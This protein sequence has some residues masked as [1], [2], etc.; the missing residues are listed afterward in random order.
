[1]IYDCFTFFN[2]LDLLEIRL[3]I[4]NDTVDKFVLVEAT[5]T[6]Q[7]KTKPL[8][9]SE[10]RDRFR[11]FQHKII[12]IVV[13]DYPTFFSKW[14]MPSAWDIE[15]HQRNAIAKGLIDCK[16]E[17]VIIVSD[18]DEIPDP[19]Q[20][21][22]FKDI[23]GLKVFQQ[24]DFYYY[25]NC[26]GLDNSEEWWYGSVMAHFNDFK[27]PQ[28]LRSVSKKMHAGKMRILK[29]R[30]YRFFKS[31]FHSIY[32]KNITMIDR[33]GWHFGYLGGVNKIIEKLEAFAHAEYNK[34]IF[35]NKLTV[36][37]AINNGMDLFG[38]GIVYSFIELDD[39]FPTYITENK[40]RLKHLIKS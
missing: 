21:T 25:L 11:S 35:K 19:K 29:D 24:R 33:G 18:L 38:R 17:D 28:E 32:R 27:N 5:R 7:G 40:D 37:T 39:S 14:R 15:K 4:L 10:N 6:H 8:Y 1:M 31:I 22:I 20:V 30:R 13:D 3:N 26:V 36:Q 9:F 16:S 34:E 23:P 2:E 12:H